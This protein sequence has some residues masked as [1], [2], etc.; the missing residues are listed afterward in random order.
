MM[1]GGIHLSSAV[2]AQALKQANNPNQTAG[3]D[4]Q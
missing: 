4:A 3:P 1:A 2:I